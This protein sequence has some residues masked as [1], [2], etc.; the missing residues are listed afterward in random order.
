[1]AC[2]L[3]AGAT[4]AE[5]LKILLNRGKIQCT[6]WGYQFD[7]FRNK[8]KKTWRP[9]GNNNFIQRVAIYIARKIILGNK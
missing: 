4:G 9:W 8:F 3:C 5:A 2:E 6:P 7:A 1:M